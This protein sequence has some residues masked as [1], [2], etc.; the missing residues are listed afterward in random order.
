M[1]HPFP[2]RQPAATTHHALHSPVRIDEQQIGRPACPQPSR[3]PA[4]MHSV[5]T[6]RHPDDVDLTWEQIRDAIRTLEGARV[7]VRIV[8]RGDPE[9]LVAAFEGTLG[10]LSHAKDPTLFWPVRLSGEHEPAAAQDTE[11]RLR[12]DRN[13]VE[14]VGFYLRP[15]RF[16]GGVG[17][18]GCTVL[19]VGQGPVLVNIRRT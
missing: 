9:M 8:E 19:V 2:S 5:Q 16:E 15:N 3:Q 18:A 7:S 11:V 1:A 12:P 6:P 13:H 14:D 17:R 4:T 10:A